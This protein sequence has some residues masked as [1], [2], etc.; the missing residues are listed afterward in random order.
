MD[1][2]PKN[3]QQANKHAPKSVRDDLKGKHHKYQKQQ[4]I[5]L[6]KLLTSDPSCIL[7]AYFLHTSWNCHVFGNLPSRCF[8][9]APPL[10]G[11][12]IASSLLRLPGGELVVRLRRGTTR[13]GLN[14]FFLFFFNSDSSLNFDSSAS[15]SFSKLRSP[16]QCLSV[17]AFCSNKSWQVGT[18]QNP[19]S[20]NSNTARKHEFNGGF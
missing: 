10:R 13:N 12:R 4:V 17:S 15:A 18:I 19:F 2:R 9:R 14:L 16:S 8:P 1:F 6:Y 3:C 7:L 20:Q 11:L 5:N